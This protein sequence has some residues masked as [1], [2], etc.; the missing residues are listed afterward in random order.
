VTKLIILS[1]STSPFGYEQ[2]MKDNSD[3]RS[4]KCLS[5]GFKFEIMSVKAPFCKL[6][7]LLFPLLLM[8]CNG[9]KHLSSGYSS[10]DLALRKKYAGMMGVKE[11]EITNLQLYRFID[12][13]YSVPY[14]SA[15][16]TK[17]GVDCS[18]F[19]S[20]LCAQVYNKTIGGPA[21]AIFASCDV[22]S[23]KNL[24]E[25]DLVFFKINSDKVSHV[26]VYLKNRRFVH[27]STHK[28]VMINSLDEEYYKK[29]FYKGGRIK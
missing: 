22:V 13:W 11:T 6:F 16:K 28:G 2:V 24:Q 9:E 1:Y 14:K 29:Y 15:G 23:E 8:A 18:G 10:E 17:S 27:A 4:Q 21:T 20:V 7:M 19:V 5:E 25:G 3:S 26:G 12:E